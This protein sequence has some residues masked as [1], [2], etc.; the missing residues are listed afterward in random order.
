MLEHPLRFLLPC[1]TKMQVFTKNATYPSPERQA[2]K[3]VQ[4]LSQGSH[5]FKSLPRS[6]GLP[7]PSRCHYTPRVASPKVLL[8]RHK[9]GPKLQ[10]HLLLSNG[11]VVLLFGLTLKLKIF[12][13]WLKHSLCSSRAASGIPCAKGNSSDSG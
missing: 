8:D 9:A 5:N 7:R 4:S 11:C 12:F 13:S 3:H 2:S 10:S 1:I 6:S